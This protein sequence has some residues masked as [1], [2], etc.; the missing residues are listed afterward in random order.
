MSGPLAR[1]IACAVSPDMVELSWRRWWCQGMR[2]DDDRRTV[3][4]TVSTE[5]KTRTWH[6][7]VRSGHMNPVGPAII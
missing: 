7:E 4:P 2:W 6:Q 5:S 3:T 1:A